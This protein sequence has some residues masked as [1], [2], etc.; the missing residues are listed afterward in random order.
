MKFIVDAHLPKKLS[1]LLEWK[2]HDSIHTLDMPSKN[3][4]KD[5]EINQLSLDEKRVL[6]TKDLDFIESL[7]ISNKPYKLIYIATGNIS[8]K[9]LLEIFSKNIE[10]VI[11]TLVE[12]RLI[13]I[14]KNE[15][16]VKG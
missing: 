9:K 1:L 6:I 11:E 3:A 5:R 2:G 16:V 7:L 8:N 13:E 12:N 15:I 4:T 10:K 14:T